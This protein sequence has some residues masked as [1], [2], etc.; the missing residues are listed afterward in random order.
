MFKLLKA[1]GVKTL[2]EALNDTGAG[3]MK[4]V[5]LHLIVLATTD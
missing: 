1:Y 5:P 4:L 3:F 2:E